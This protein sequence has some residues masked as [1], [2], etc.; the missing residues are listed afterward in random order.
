MVK[1]DYLKIVTSI[2]RLKNEKCPTVVNTWKGCFKLNAWYN[3]Q[4]ALIEKLQQQIER[5]E[6]VVVIVVPV[7]FQV[8]NG[9]VGL[10]RDVILRLIRLMSENPKTRAIVGMCKQT[11][12]WKNVT[13]WFAW[14][15]QPQCLPVEYKRFG[16]PGVGEVEYDG[17][18]L[19]NVCFCDHM[20]SWVNLDRDVGDDVLSLSVTVPYFEALRVVEIGVQ[21]RHP[22][23]RATYQ[24]TTKTAVLNLDYPRK[25]Y[26]LASTWAGVGD[27][28]LT[29]VMHG[30]EKRVTFASGLRTLP[31]R[32]VNIPKFRKTYLGVFYLDYY[33]YHSI[34]K[35]WNI[36]GR[37]TC[38]FSIV[39][40]T[41]R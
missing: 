8:F 16:L 33:Y 4:E 31:Y 29:A 6:I 11:L 3:K 21:S 40:E 27:V 32:V 23:E 1:C 25:Y 5:V 28:L 36:Q 14:A 30:G 41:S 7:E 19:K 15:M 34:I 26:S 35:V 17:P 2:T 12:E 24:M 18:D 13:M 9:M 20:F 37:R 38:D 39:S 22:D 10:N